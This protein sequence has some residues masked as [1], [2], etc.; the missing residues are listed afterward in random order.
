L[1][2]GAGNMVGVGEHFEGAC[3]WAKGIRSAGY[4]PGRKGRLVLLNGHLHSD[5]HW[6]TSRPQDGK[7]G[8][9]QCRNVYVFTVAKG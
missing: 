3:W 4:T 6:R 2:A 9:S 1:D 7:A 8:L 5:H